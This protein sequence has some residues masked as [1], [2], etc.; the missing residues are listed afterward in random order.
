[1]ECIYGRN[2]NYNTLKQIVL[3]P[4]GNMI[5]GV[6]NMNP[7]KIGESN[8]CILKFDLTDNTIRM[9]DM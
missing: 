2:I 6:K 7:G 4:S 8:E 3:I 1:M 9:L 5:L